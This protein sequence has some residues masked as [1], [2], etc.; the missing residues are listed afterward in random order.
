MSHGPPARFEE[1]GKR[2]GGLGATIGHRP[3]T[4]EGALSR[5]QKGTHNI[6]VLTTVLARDLAPL[7]SNHRFLRGLERLTPGWP[8]LPDATSLLTARVYV[9]AAGLAEGVSVEVERRRAG[10]KTF[11]S[12]R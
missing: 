5:A 11:G 8:I 3:Q 1:A 4:G 2:H 9:R 12:K 6:K 10:D 7:S